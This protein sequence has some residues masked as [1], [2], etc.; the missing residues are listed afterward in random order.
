MQS[1]KRQ[2][3]LYFQGKPFNITV[4]QAYAS[5]SNAEEAEVEWFYKELQDLLDPTPKKDVF[6][7][8]G[9]WNVKI[10]SQETPGVTGKFGLGIQNEAGQRLIEFCQENALVIVNTLFQKHKRRLYT[11]TSPDGQ[12]QNQIDYILCSQR[13]RSSVQLAKTRLGADCGSDHELLIAKF[14]LKLK[15]VGKTTRPFRYYLNQIPYD[16]TVEVRNRFKG[17][18]LIEC[19]MNYGQRFVTLYRRQGLRPSPW[20][21]NAKK[22]NGCLRR[23]YK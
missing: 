7:I 5:T 16:Y 4:I 21:R 18:D 9:D 17:L 6:F 14:R 12:H 10:G 1:Q 20:K 8:I 13:W 15:K 2:N 23:P 22:Q 19:L 3:D 11:W